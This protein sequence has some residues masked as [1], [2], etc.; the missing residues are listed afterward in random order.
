MA[1]RRIAKSA[2]DWHAFAER[3]PPNQKEFYR[4]FKAKSD[5]FVSRVH[6]FPEKLPEIDFSFYASRLDSAMVSEFEKSY[7]ALA[8]PYPKDKGNLKVEIEKS[9]KEAKARTE[10]EVATARKEIADSKAL[11]SK[12]DSIPGPGVMTHE[13]YSDYF[14]DI[15]R[16]P[17]TRPTFW[18][19]TKAYQ[20][21]ND[22]H[23]I[24]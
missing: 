16:N 5:L 10:K 4:A 7:K 22:P 17:W 8:I 24:H 2:V 12:I 19:H 21:E 14:P 23:T 3:V 13:M 11:L 9:E 1:A 20:P 6:R 18:P 15:A